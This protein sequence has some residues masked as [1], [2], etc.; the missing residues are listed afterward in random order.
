MRK[1]IDEVLDF[2]VEYTMHHKYDQ[3]P[4]FTTQLLSE[5]LSM[6]RTNISSILNQLVAEGKVVKKGG[7][8]VLYQLNNDINR[9][10]EGN[11]SNVI[12]H[13]QSMKEAIMI[14]QAAILY[15][16]K[17]TS[18][19]L[20]AES[21]SGVRYFSKEIHQFAI[22]SR[23]VKENAPFIIFDCRNFMESPETIGKL[24]FGN[25]DNQGILFQANKGVLLIKNA[26]LLPGYE[27]TVLFSILKEMN[28]Y[29]DENI[30]LPNDFKCILICTIGKQ[31]DA[32]TIE[33]YKD[34]IDFIIDIPSLIERGIDERYELITH[35]F[36]NEARMLGRTISTQSSLLHS[37]LLY[38]TKNNIRGLQNDIHT[39]CANSYARFH[40]NKK[41]SIEILLSD[42]P[43]YVRKGM[44]YYKSYRQQIN[45]LVPG[46]CKYSFTQDEVL[47]TNAIIKSKNIYQSLDSKKRELKKHDINEDDINRI[48]SLDLHEE[49][50]DYYKRIIHPLHTLEQLQNFISQTL[51]SNVRS[52]LDDIE[53][54]L[55]YSV[56]DSV[57]Y[58]ICMHLNT[59]LIRMNGKQRISNEEIKRLTEVYP[60]HYQVS[61]MF[62]E[63]IEKE[64]G[65]QLNI[66]EVVYIMMFLLSEKE[67]EIADTVV[68]LIVMHGDSSGTSI[69]TVINKMTNGN[70][71]FGYNLSLE[72]NMEQAYGEL[73]ELIRTINRGKGLLIIYDMGSIRTMIESI[74]FEEQIP[75]EFMEMPV[76]LLGIACNNKA[77]EGHSLQEIYTY[78]QENFRDIQYTRNNNH[79]KVIIV[80]SNSQEEASQ[81]ITYLEKTCNLNMVE[82]IGLQTENRNHLYTEVYNIS[83]KNKIVGVIGG[84]NPHLSQF[85]FLSI[86][87]LFTM[88]TTEILE[89]FDNE[90]DLS[91]IYGYIQDQFEELDI[92][93]LRKHLDFFIEQLEFVLEEKLNNDKKI[94]LIMHIASLINRVL[95]QQ[96]TEAN[97]I[98][99]SILQKNFQLVEKI[100]RILSPVESAFHIQINDIEIAT[101]ISIIKKSN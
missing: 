62:I 44:I 70:T 101:I 15:P 24:I 83:K 61:K 80:V 28:L 37:L 32:G 91:N 7:R 16:Q 41:Q 51:I 29:A 31:T 27:R 71:T 19:L 48:V 100:K 86:D 18:I 12:G 84:Y 56:S 78:L 59:A 76:T 38:E 82:I 26:D 79:K 97:T 17:N 73:K 43:N 75:V 5:K 10:E 96:E 57:F 3:Y 46:G 4:T 42:F 52:L 72:S 54:E 45:T 98:I 88:Q 14:A 89:V 23:I 87:R 13:K 85:P 55:G 93:V 63:A 90:D 2:I 65:M 6:Q 9:M 95:K 47:K 67:V 8:P 34:K 66:D 77:I 74:S 35:F 30:H 92:V 22:K 25:R 40:G 64:F 11:F 68:T 49:F 81:A 58:G 33:I 50:L 39:G 1:K 60:K 21:G 69:A 99:S 20:I 53:I 36:K 94:G